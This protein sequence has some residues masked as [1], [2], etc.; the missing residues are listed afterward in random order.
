M[1]SYAVEVAGPTTRYDIV[2]VDGTIFYLKGA[3]YESRSTLVA[4]LSE[5]LKPDKAYVCNEWIAQDHIKILKP[6]LEPYRAELIKATLND[7][8]TARK[9]LNEIIGL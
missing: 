5:Q 6:L 3:W 9:I 8:L 2:T 1:F 4:N 7:C